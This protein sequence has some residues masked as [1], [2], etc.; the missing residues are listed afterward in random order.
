MAVKTVNEGYVP[1]WVV[2]LSQFGNPGSGSGL[3]FGQSRAPKCPT[4]VS[5]WDFYSQTS[6][7]VEEDATTE[8][9]L[10]RWLLGR[11]PSSTCRLCIRL[12]REQQ[13]HWHHR[14]KPPSVLRPP[15]LVQRF[16]CRNPKKTLLLGILELK[17]S[18]RLQILTYC[19]AETAKPC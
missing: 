13:G 19:E 8:G 16:G 12:G 3:M 9:G 14:R 17:K 2:S 1:S 18:C 10:R 6:G 11:S 5:S 4:A 7:Q 15:Q